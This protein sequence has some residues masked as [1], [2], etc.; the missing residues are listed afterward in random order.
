MPTEY[1][2]PTIIDS[3]ETFIQESDIT[4]HAVWFTY[5]IESFA[6]EID[7]TAQATWFL[8]KNWDM[9][10]IFSRIRLQCSSYMILMQVLVRK[11]HALKNQTSMLMLYDSP[12]QKPVHK[13]NLLENQT[14]QLMLYDSPTRLVHMSHLLENQASLLKLHD[15]PTR[16]GSYESFAQKSIIAHTEWFTKGTSSW[17]SFAWEPDYISHWLCCKFYAESYWWNTFQYCIP[18]SFFNSILIGARISNH[19]NNL[20]L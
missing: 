4:A 11:N 6:W 10:I 7:I 2:W 18:Y 8:Y 12:I 17:E 5:K 20:M 15:S 3:K 13:T 19:Q 9:R 16:T 1:G 14:S